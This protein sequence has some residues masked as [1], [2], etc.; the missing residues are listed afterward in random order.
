M[1]NL[2]KKDKPEDVN[3]QPTPKA[4]KDSSVNIIFWCVVIVTGFIVGAG[5]YMFIAT[6]DYEAKYAKF[7]DRWIIQRNAIYSTAIPSDSVLTKVIPVRDSIRAKG[8]SSQIE[9]SDYLVPVSEISKIQKTQKILLMRQDQLT[10]DIRQETNNII[11]KMN[12]WLG[13]WMAVMAILGVFVPIALQIKLYRE[14]RDSDERLK[15][16]CRD[17][18]DH[19][20]SEASTYLTKYET[21]LRTEQ[22]K[23]TSELLKTEIETKQRFDGLKSQFQEEY[24]KDK[25]ELQRIRFA[26]S[27]RSF[28]TISDSPEIKNTDVRNE[29]LKNN[30]LEILSLVR[31]FIEQYISESPEKGNSYVLSVVLVQVVSVVTALRLLCT[32][33]N[34]QLEA[35]SS[36]SY[37]IIEG[38]NSGSIDRDSIFKKLK[39]YQESLFQLT[40]LVF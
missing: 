21:A 3:K 10:D 30:W 19:L 11:N 14:N 37:K 12:G 7:E 25:N 15:Q 1:C 29:L 28:H 38:L 6:R 9:V 22:A 5:I 23:I 17:E 35:L 24:R 34:R 26:A 40:P 27:I 8:N 16:E 2:G 18:F 39:N 36:E 31:I 33:R 32:K 4:N 20:R 13:F